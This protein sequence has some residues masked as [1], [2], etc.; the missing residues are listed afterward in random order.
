MSLHVLNDSYN[1]LCLCHVKTSVEAPWLSNIQTNCAVIGQGMLVCV[2]SPTLS[3]YMLD[4]H[5]QSQMTQIPLQV[6]T[7]MYFFYHFSFVIML[8]HINKLCCHYVLSSSFPQSLGLEVAPG[9]HPVL[10]ST[11]PNPARQPLSEFFLQVAPEHHLLLQ[12]NN[13]QIVTLRDFK[14][15][16][17][18]HT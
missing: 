9:F 11:Q 12:L 1:F 13:G 8:C 6:G 4:L 18:C 3:L 10:V 2:D 14:P 17:H 16:S 7:L 15:V 5:E